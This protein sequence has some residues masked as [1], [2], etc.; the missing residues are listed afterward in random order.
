RDRV[1]R[2]GSSPHV[3]RRLVGDPA[4]DRRPTLDDGSHVVE[5]LSELRASRSN[6]RDVDLEHIDESALEYHVTQ[7]ALPVARFELCDDRRV[8]IER[9]EIREDDVTFDA[10]GIARAHMTG[11]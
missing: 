9:I 10:S 3:A 5:I 4:C 6:W 1:E 2:K 7:P 8:R 11:I